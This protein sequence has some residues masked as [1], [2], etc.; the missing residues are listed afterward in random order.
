MKINFVQYE[1]IAPSTPNGLVAYIV[2]DK[3]VVFSGLIPTSSSTINS[4]EAIL[5][6]ICER[7]KLDWRECTFIDIQTRRCYERFKKF[8]HELS[9]LT[10]YQNTEKAFVMNWMPAEESELPA[11]CIELFDE[12]PWYED[13]PSTKLDDLKS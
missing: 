8:E 9:R 1:P 6:A 7:E 10:L 11:G 4:A 5:V 12:L 13:T 2:S 3:L